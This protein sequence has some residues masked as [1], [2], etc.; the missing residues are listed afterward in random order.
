M[1]INRGADSYVKIGV[2]KETKKK[3]AI[4]VIEKKKHKPSRLEAMMREIEILGR[5]DHPHI[6][7]LYEAYESK[8]NIYLVLE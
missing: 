7:K 4:K 1:T 3:V 8:D 5:L 6:I 2:N